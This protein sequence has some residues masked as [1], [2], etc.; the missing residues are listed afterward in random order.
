M[1]WHCP[2]WRHH[3]NQAW[4]KDQAIWDASARKGVP[5]PS[6][7]HGPKPTPCDRTAHPTCW[8]ATPSLPPVNEE[9]EAD[10]DDMEF[11]HELDY[12]FHNKN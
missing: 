11:G 9:D 12:D 4:I 2:Y 8:G 1:D 10:D 7:L 3:F 6:T 5:P